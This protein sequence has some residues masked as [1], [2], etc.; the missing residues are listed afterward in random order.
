MSGSS[1]G[2]DVLAPNYL[3]D[4]LNNRG[5]A[6]L[7]KNQGFGVAEATPSSSY[8]APDREKDRLRTAKAREFGMTKSTVGF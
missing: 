8:G 3:G 6:D 4:T 1:E 7:G 5:V 2:F